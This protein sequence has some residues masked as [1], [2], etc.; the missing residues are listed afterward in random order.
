MSRENLVIGVHGDLSLEGGRYNVLSSFTAG[1]LKGFQKLGAKA[2][3]LS[4]CLNKK[5]M[6]NLTIGFNVTGYDSWQS[7]MD[8]NIVNI[9][10]T[11]DSIFAQN[12][13]VM[14]QFSKNP[15]FILFTVT[16][17]DTQPLIEYFPELKHAYIPHATD[18]DLW[19]RQ[20]VEK[21]Y[22][23][24]LLSSI[25]DYEAK[26][27]E[28][29]ST[30]PEALFNLMMEIYNISMENPT[31]SFWDIYQA[32]KAQNVLNL[33]AEQYVYL[34]RNLA[35][36]IMHAKKVQTVQQLSDF[37]VK[38]F[39]GGPWEKYISGN[40]QK[41]G[42]CNLKESIDI[43]NKSKIVL[44]PH[45]LPLSLGLHERVLNASAVETFV[46]SSEAITIHS[47]FQDTMAFFNSNT[48]EDLP[49]KLDYFLQNDEERIFKAKAARKI[50]EERHTW[51]KRAESII[52]IIN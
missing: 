46:L 15:N 36:I 2:Y 41:M 26:L 45:A 20:D 43:M 35:Y 34:F 5:T 28:I 40:I 6:P 19:K 1:L 37:N 11:V 48:F 25:E 51:D 14:R 12:Y 30:T 38:I 29:K 49:E 8:N 16:P 52:Q 50:V 27:E 13:E 7:L 39:G 17:C 22:D 32:Y 4:E 3:T 21:E 10:W 9:M 24:V 23:I 47:E 44:H 18:L 31:I 42:P 33:D